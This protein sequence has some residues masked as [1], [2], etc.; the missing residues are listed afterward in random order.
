MSR[1][2]KIGTN[3]LHVISLPG[4]YRHAPQ[5]RRLCGTE[6]LR[7]RSPVLCIGAVSTLVPVQHADVVLLD[8]NDNVEMMAVHP[9]GSEDRIAE[10]LD[11]K[12]NKHPLRHL[13]SLVQ[14]WNPICR[15]IY[16]RIYGIRAIANI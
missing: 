13:I 1:G 2:S 8:L 14:C 9:N 4:L 6:G 12:V 15:P 5:L 3:N 16:T 7:N 10:S 11:K